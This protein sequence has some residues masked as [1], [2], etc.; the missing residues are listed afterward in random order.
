MYPT[1]VPWLTEDEKAT[2][3]GSPLAGGHSTGGA[4]SEQPWQPHGTVNICSFYG[5]MIIRRQQQ[6]VKQYPRFRTG[7][8]L[9]TRTKFQLGYSIGRRIVF[10]SGPK[11]TE[12]NRR[13]ESSNHRNL[14]LMQQILIIDRLP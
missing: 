10:C 6:T 13:C 7:R 3:I 8:Q 12:K 5:K 11:R 9:P 4:F 1:A 2:D 14:V